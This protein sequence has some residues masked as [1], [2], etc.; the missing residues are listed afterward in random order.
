MPFIYRLYYWHYSITSE[1]SQ[2][3][4][5][6]CVRNCT[7][8][9]QILY[10]RELSTRQNVVGVSN[11]PTDKKRTGKKSLWQKTQKLLG[12]QSSSKVAQQKAW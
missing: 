3:L 10:S 5:L 7:V 4:A 11:R 1:I 12:K 8:K 2:A 9:Q 6:C